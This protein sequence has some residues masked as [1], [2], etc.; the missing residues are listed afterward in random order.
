MSRHSRM[1]RCERKCSCRSSVSLRFD[2]LCLSASSKKLQS[3]R[4]DEEVRAL[5]LELLV[6]AV[7]GFG[8]VERAL[9]RVLDRQR[10]GDDQHLAQAL[11]ALRGEHHARDAR[12]DRE[13]RELPADLRELVVLVDRAELREELVAVGD[14]ARRRRIEEREVLD[15]ADAQRLHAQDHRR[16]RRAQDLGIGELA[17]AP[18]NRLRE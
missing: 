6:R 3:F 8:A 9:A 7:G 18:R 11:L 2:F 17:A 12:I 5:V 15:V 13:S 16:E 10:R 4:Y 14:H 1:R